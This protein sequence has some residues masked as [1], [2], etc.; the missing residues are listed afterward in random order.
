[1]KKKGRQ[2]HTP[3][4]L[5]STVLGSQL[6]YH[7]RSIREAEE[8]TVTSGTFLTSPKVQAALYT[9]QQALDDALINAVQNRRIPKTIARLVAQG[10]YI[11]ALR[12]GL[13][14]LLIAVINRDVETLTTLL[15]LGADVHTTDPYGNTALHLIALKPTAKNITQAEIL[16]LAGAA[17]NAQNHLG[18]T[19]LHL[20][21]AKTKLQKTFCQLLLKHHAQL[22]IVDIKGNAPLAKLP[23]SVRAEL[24]RYAL[25]SFFG[26]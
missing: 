8:G 22:D 16:L 15:T 24:M 12:D 6:V 5:C 13:S 2:A 18:Q 25:F 1:M 9:A 11:N 26:R 4:H 19:P 14:P 3:A 23:E 20:C 10:A 21:G 17:V 7:Q